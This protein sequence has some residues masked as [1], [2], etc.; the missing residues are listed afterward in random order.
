MGTLTEEAYTGTIKSAEEMLALAQQALSDVYQVGQSYFAPG[1]VQVTMA[2]V[3]KLK[4]QVKYWE[5]R[6]LAKRGA[7]GRNI[8]DIAPGNTENNTTL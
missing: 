6:V 4:D 5:K 8:A 2:D 3:E 1:G 7:D